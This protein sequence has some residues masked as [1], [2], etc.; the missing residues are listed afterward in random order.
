MTELLPA[1]ERRVALDAAGPLPVAVGEQ[2][3]VVQAA[4][5]HVQGAGGPGGGLGRGR[6][7]PGREIEGQ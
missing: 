4:L 3:A 6:A 5:R 7:H 2:P 1:F